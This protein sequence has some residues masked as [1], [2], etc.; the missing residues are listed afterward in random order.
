[1][2]RLI[3][4]TVFVMIAAMI[5]TSAWAATV[6]IQRGTYGTVADAYIRDSEPPGNTTPDSN[7]NFGDAVDPTGLRLYADT[8][9]ATVKGQR[10]MLIRFDLGFIPTGSIITSATFG[11]Y[12]RPS[13]ASPNI[14]DLKLSRVQASKSWIE[15]VGDKSEDADSM[16]WPGEPTFMERLHGSV[17]W[18]TPG[19]TGAADIDLTTTKYY[20]LTGASAG[21]R[22]VDVTSFVEGWVNGGWANTGMLMWGGVDPTNSSTRWYENVSEDATVANRPYL[23]I[24]YTPIPEPGSLLALGSGLIAMGGFALR[25][26]RA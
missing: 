23:T 5:A 20:N 13:G 26:R 21:F 9:Y 18:Q 8:G 25:R 6:T 16:A 24:N 2:K 19:A 11:E 4:L 12:Y 10:H 15:G 7:S 22:T 1:M 14:T 3:L 17:A